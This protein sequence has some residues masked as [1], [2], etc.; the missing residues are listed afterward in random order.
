MKQF[1]VYTLLGLAFIVG[2]TSIVVTVRP[3]LSKPIE[4]RTFLKEVP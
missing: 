3:Q 2:F 4:T 1:F